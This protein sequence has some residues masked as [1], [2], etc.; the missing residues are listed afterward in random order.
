MNF[1]FFRDENDY[2]LRLEPM[3]ILTLAGPRRHTNNEYC[4]QFDDEEPYVFGMGNDPLTLTINSTDDGSIQ[5]QN[6]G[7]T[8]KIF[9]RER[10]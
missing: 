4:F 7:R 8:F 10:Q 5:F 1:K 3:Q 2:L 9:A 6:N